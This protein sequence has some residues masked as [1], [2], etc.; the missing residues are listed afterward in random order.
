[1]SLLLAPTR[2]LVVPVGTRQRWLAVSQTAR[3]NLDSF[4]V[5]VFDWLGWSQ[6]ESKPLSDFGGELV[7]EGSPMYSCGT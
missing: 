2:M 6:T 7:L 4:K 1:M 5:T 3:S